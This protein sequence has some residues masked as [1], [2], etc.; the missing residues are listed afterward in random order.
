MLRSTSGSAASG[1]LRPQFRWSTS[2]TLYARGIEVLAPRSAGPRS[3]PAVDHHRRLAV[4][5]AADLPVDAVPV[6]DVEHAVV[7]RLDLGI[8]GRLPGYNSAVRS[9]MDGAIGT[10]LRH[11]L[12][13]LDGD[14]AKVYLDLGVPTTGRGSRRSSAP[15][16]PRDRCRSVTWRPRSASRI[17]PRARPS[18]NWPRPASPR[19]SRART[20]G[21]GSSSSRD[22]TRDL[23]PTIEA[24]WQATTA[25]M[26][27]L[28]A[29]LTVPLAQTLEELVG[30]VNR[31]PFRKRIADHT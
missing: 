15:W 23:L 1:V 26:K 10:Q 2:T 3:R 29:E 7:V 13:L 27:E 24:E 8:H 17:R 28:D 14:V 4:R 31:R 25:A 16:S 21:N 19:F 30:A 18:P 5:V 22:K 12:E 9:T 11:V 6:A 20:P